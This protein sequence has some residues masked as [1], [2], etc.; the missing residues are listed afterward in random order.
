MRR[1]LSG[2]LLPL[3]IVLAGVAVFVLMQVMGRPPTRVEQAYAG[4]LVESV[5]AAPKALQI[6]VQ[7]Q[8]TVRPAAQIDLVP[9]VSGVIVWKSPQ[10]E[11]GGIFGRGELLARIDPDEYELA[12]AVAEA[13][14]VRAEYLLEL[15]R[16]EADAARQEW[17]VQ[18]ATS[19]DPVSGK[20]PDPLVLRL[21]QV[22]VAEADLRAARAR[23]REAG[24]RLER[25]ELSAPFD[26]RVRSCELAEGQFVAVGR[27]VARLYSIES[28]Q[29]VVPVP[30]EDLAWLELSSSGEPPAV[31]VRGQYAGREHEWQGH[32]VRLEGEVDPRSRMARVVIE[33][34]GPHTRVAHGGAPLVV[35]MFVNVEIAGRQLTGV[36][37]IPRSGL[38][39]G[40]TIWVAGPDG[41]LRV[42]PVQ[43]LRAGSEDLLV[44]AEMATDERIVTSRIRAVTDGMKVRLTEGARP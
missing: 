31:A 32:A 16:G 13:Q 2:V 3:V 25:T 42:L 22:R 1:A 39:P 9:Q 17:E 8:G 10:L 29:I 28:A 19:G 34:D 35:G 33:V 36:R 38:R 41:I 27:A 6:T 15:A 44:R 30:D 18:G 21:P 43:V 7:G 4:P 23:L 12:V 26:G 37:S 40:S 5:S 14:V 24:L 20:T 11:S